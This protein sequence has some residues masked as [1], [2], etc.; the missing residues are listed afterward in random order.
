MI[1]GFPF[2]KYFDVVPNWRSRQLTLHYKGT[3]HVVD[4]FT[5]RAESVSV[6]RLIGDRH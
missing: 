1:L 2:L 6:I 4:C 3:F 5:L